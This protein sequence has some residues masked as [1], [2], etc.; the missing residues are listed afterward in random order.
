MPLPQPH[1]ISAFL[2]Y[3][4][5]P[6]LMVH[7]LIL[8]IPSPVMKTLKIIE[9]GRKRK[10]KKSKTPFLILQKKKTTTKKYDFGGLLIFLG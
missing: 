7:F 10:G 3:F 8:I 4:L 1:P 9:P 2:F 6:D 5:S